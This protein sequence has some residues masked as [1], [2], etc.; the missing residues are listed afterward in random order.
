M[1]EY[2]VAFY[3]P[4]IGPALTITTGDY[5][6]GAETQIVALGRGL[7]AR[8][9]KVAM[10]TFDTSEGLPRQVDGIDIVVRPSY[11]RRL[12]KVREPF[13]AMRSLGRVKARCLVQRCAS[14]ET[15]VAA[16]VARTTGTPFIYS[17][18]NDG[19]FHMQELPFSWWERAPYRWGVRSAAEI[20]V[21]T[22][23]QVA[24]C[25]QAF[26][27]DPVLI[28]SI[29]ELGPIHS[30]P[31]QD[32]LWISRLS[33]YKH[34]EIFVRIAR[35][36]P[37]VPFTMVGI[38]DPAWPA[39]DDVLREARRLSNVE[40]IRGLPRVAALDR[41]GR[42]AAVVSTS[43]AEGMPNIFL[44]AW[45]RGVPAVSL[46]SDPVGG[47]AERGLG[48]HC[49]GSV[50]HLVSRVQELWSARDER[51]HLTACRNFVLTE[52]AREKALDQ[53]AELLARVMR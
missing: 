50:E 41:I 51:R 4:R 27:R 45:G 16:G 20:V 23:D 3:L 13:H 14:F 48:Y 42:A 28:K 43:T 12:Q 40:V 34:P 46:H 52:H 15:S 22:E 53:W 37:E 7:A 26:G 9:W 5:P 2:D 1:Q 21:Q 49:G 25:R 11:G 44:E 30:G 19:D 35:A 38:S 29:A 32:I 17:S 36:L 18:A 24:L 31:G 10:V 47:L 8:G 39:G 6:G 33:S